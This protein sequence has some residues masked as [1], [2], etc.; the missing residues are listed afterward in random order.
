MDVSLNPPS[1]TLLFYLCGISFFF[2][3]PFFW[4]G[5][6]SVVC[7]FFF[8]PLPPGS[9]RLFLHLWWFSRNY[10]ILTYQMSKTNLYFTLGGNPRTWDHPTT[11]SECYCILNFFNPLVFAAVASVLVLFRFVDIPASFF[12]LY[13]FCI[14]DI[15]SELTCSCSSVHALEMPFIR[16]WGGKLSPLLFGFPCCSGDGLADCRIQVGCWVLS[17]RH[18]VLA[19][20]VLC[21]LT[22]RCQAISSLQMIWLFLWLLTSKLKV[23]VL[24]RMPSRKWKDNPQDERKYANNSF[25]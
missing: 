8:L 21:L 14:S 24:Q 12:A 2:P 17:V 5:Y 22:N 15:P 18:C 13:S 4:V 11:P 9:Y 1:Y 20:G 6:W 10:N 16:F 7:F 25:D 3:S 23:F 19:S